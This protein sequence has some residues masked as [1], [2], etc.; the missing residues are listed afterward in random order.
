MVYDDLL[1]EI[2]EKNIP[3]TSF[4]PPRRSRNEYCRMSPVKT[5]SKSA[6]VGSCD[7]SYNIS[8]QKRDDDDAGDDFDPNTPSRP[9][10]DRR[11]AHPPAPRSTSGKAAPQ[12]S[13][14]K[15]KS[16][17]YCSQQC[18]LGLIKGGTLDRKCPNV[19]DHGVD[20]HRLTPAT[21]ISQLDRQ[22]FSDHQQLDTQI[23]CESLHVHGSRGALFKITL[24]SHGYTFVGKG[25]PVEF[26]TGSKHEELI[27]SHLAPIQGLYV[28]VLLGSL[29]LRHPFPYDGIAE[30]V[31]LMFMSYVGKPL[32]NRRDLDRCPQ[33]HQQVE[34]SLHAIHELNVLQGDPIPGNMVEENGRVMFI[35]FER[36]KLQP[37]RLPLGGISPN[38][39]RKRE[40]DF[41]AISQD[42]NSHHDCFEREKRRMRNAL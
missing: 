5:R 24:W 25:T 4:K 2:A 20:R 16:R 35:D 17:Q 33:I 11:L 6:G 26:V 27:Y 19:S 42:K 22:F 28:P 14:Y 32:A 10:R 1:D 12:G 37:R 3:F 13:G 36:A 18:L 38:H 31:H 9:P 40:I 30:I 41:P 21:L 34:K 7:P 8:S 39:K 15:G 23:G 29:R